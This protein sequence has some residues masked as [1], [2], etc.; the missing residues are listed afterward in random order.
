MRESELYDFMAHPLKMDKKAVSELSALVDQFPYFHT[1]HILLSLSAKN[2]DT[3]LY[4]NTIKRTAISVSSREQLYELIQNSLLIEETP[5]QEQ[6]KKVEIIKE[7]KTLEQETLVEPKNI[8]KIET[9]PIKTENL[10]PEIQVEKITPEK[11]EKEIERSVVNSFIEKEVLQIKQDKPKEPQSF[12]DWLTFVDKHKEHTTE[13]TAQKKDVLGKQEEDIK[14]IK[15][16]QK[17]LIDKI[18]ESNP[19]AI[20]NKE[21]QKFFK[22]E[23]K[24]KESLLES[25]DLVTETLASIY[26]SQGNISKAVRAYE[27]LSL[28]YPQKSA[29]FASLIEKLKNVQKD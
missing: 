21:E 19:G 6:E 17:A 15:L 4:Q 29:Y 22:A 8:E 13:I 11:V 20:R 28:K 2:W 9:T 7:T 12:T 25:E 10:E 16:K 14:K 5:I 26:A 3:T 27:L 1:A 23:I 18:I 24:T